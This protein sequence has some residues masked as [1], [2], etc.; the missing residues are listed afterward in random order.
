MESVPESVRI[1][2][3]HIPESLLFTW[4]IWAFILVISVITAKRA[5]L[6]P[7][8]IQSVYEMILGY[9]TDLADELIGPEAYKFYPLFIG[10][11]IFIL[12]GNLI[13]SSPRFKITYFR[14]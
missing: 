2:L 10:L 6:V 13:G 14:S 4:A 3:G 11:F 9:V 8:K 7:T 1:H 5:S 12:I